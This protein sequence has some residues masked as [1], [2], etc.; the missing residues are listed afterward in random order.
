MALQVTVRN[1]NLDMALRNLRKKQAKDGILSEVKK[2]EAYDKPG[3][4]R[5][6]KKEAGIKNT[7]RKNKKERRD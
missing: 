2:R 4:V 6:E 1:G 7:Q 3:K 5:R